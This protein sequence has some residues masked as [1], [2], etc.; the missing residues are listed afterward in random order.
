MAVCCPANVTGEG[1]PRFTLHQGRHQRLGSYTCTL[2]TRSQVHILYVPFIATLSPDLGT[3]TILHTTRHG[4]HPGSPLEAYARRAGESNPLSA[5]PFTRP[6]VSY[7][8][9]RVALNLSIRGPI[10]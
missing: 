1:G 10:V 6:L 8:L 2:S 9:F 3:I 4:D 7:N 5:L